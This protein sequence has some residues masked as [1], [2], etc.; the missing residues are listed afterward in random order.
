MITKFGC[1]DLEPDWVRAIFMDTE[2]WPVWN[3][4]T[5]ASDWRFGN[6]CGDA[7]SR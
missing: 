6:G 4:S 7:R 5:G 3:R 1:V 2:N